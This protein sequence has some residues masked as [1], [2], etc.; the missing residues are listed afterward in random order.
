MTVPPT[1]ILSWQ[2]LVLE[3]DPGFERAKRQPWVYTF[4]N[5]RRFYSPVN[6]YAPLPPGLENNGGFLVLAPAAEAGFPLSPVG[7][8]PGEIWSNGL[9]VVVVDGGI[10]QFGSPPM[11][12][13]Q[14]SAD[15]LL[16][17]GG[18]SLPLVQ[19]PVGSLILWNNG[20]F[21]CVS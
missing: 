18:A 11:I 15:Q 17:F 14:I 1:R 6:P 20:G 16:T 12:F 3:A 13:G 21:V 8:L 5:G 4:S 10:P 19:P 9:F 2:Q 7:L